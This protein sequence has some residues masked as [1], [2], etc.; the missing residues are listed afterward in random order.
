MPY[1]QGESLRARINREEQLPVAE[2]VRIASE[3]ASGLGYAHRQGVVH[4]DI[5]S[6][7]VLFHDGRAMITDFGIALIRSGGDTEIR[8]TKA[9]VSL[10]TPQYMSPEQASGVHDL[11][12]R[13]DIYSL[14]AVL[15]EMLSGQPPFVG[16][17]GAGGWVQPS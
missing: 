6:D 8:L 13:T 11:D 15:Y 3:V 14:G 4:R 1:L 5:K 7:N 12:P 9:G 2:A 10:G 16:P 17:L